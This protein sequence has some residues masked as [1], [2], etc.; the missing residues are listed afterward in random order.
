MNFDLYAW[1]QRLLGLMLVLLSLLLGACRGNPDWASASVSSELTSLTLASG[2][3]DQSFQA[4]QPDY[5]ST[6]GYLV[7]SISVIPQAADE[8]ATIKVAGQVVDSGAQSPPIALA[9]GG[10]TEIGIDVTAAGGRSARHY[11]VTVARQALDGFAQQA[12]LKASNGGVQDF[13]GYSVALAGDTLAIGAPQEDSAQSG[14][15]PGSPDE[16][17]AGDDSNKSGA[18]Y[19]FVRTGESWVQQAYLKGSRP[20]GDLDYFGTSVALSGNTLAVG[21][22]F[23]NGAAP[24]DKS[25]WNK[26][27]AGNANAETS[28][29]V[30]DSGAVYVFVRDAT[31]EWHQQAYLK[32]S[33]AGENAH[34]GTTVALSGDTLAVGAEGE[35]GALTGVFMGAPDDAL[36]GNDV[37]DS[38]AVYVFTRNENGGWSQQAYLKALNAGSD[39]WFG[40]SLALSGNT[41]A[42]GAPFEDGA[43]TGIVP[44]GADM[45]F[46]DSLG[47]PKIGDGAEMSGAVYIFSRNDA[48]HW[49]QEAYVKGSNTS[50]RDG[51][52]YSVA[53]AD[54]TLA[55]GAY[56]QEEDSGAVY[57]FERGSDWRWR[58]QAYLK[59]SNAGSGDNFGW[60]VAVS[61]GRLAVGTAAESGGASGVILGSPDDRL[62][63]NE[64]SSAGAAYL[65]MRDEKGDWLQQAYAKAS[66]VSSFDQFG[67][68]V[69]LSDDQLAI[70]A[71]FEAG[72]VHGVF[73]GSPSSAETGD[74]S[75]ESGAVYV[76]R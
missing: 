75:A 1:M 50:A 38:G 36:T 3:L 31:G 11:T 70:S 24:I 4:E 33:N 57:V 74:G 46:G 53:L 28:A 35:D 65:F 43:V 58:Q 27:T 55:V 21:A 32:A 26:S 45:I 18:V 10:E 62:T 72:T 66:N 44:S 19:V 9:A 67:Y 17:S 6:Q 15:I 34:F 25:Q 37:P 29:S 54:N 8:A 69:A 76:F 23:E 64:A 30:P 12:Y 47:S 63:G 42:V 22:P 71:P 14:I 16:S 52:G 73:A 56:R 40:F 2:V 5:T 13:F 41:L 59:A 49:R 61:K 20:K 60:S 7:R 48:Q 51:F 68:A 39:D